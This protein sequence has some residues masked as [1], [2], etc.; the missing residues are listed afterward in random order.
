MTL[1]GVGHRLFVTSERLRVEHA[2]HHSPVTAVLLAGSRE[3]RPPAEDRHQYV[4]RHGEVGCREFE[5][6]AYGLRRGEHD[7]RT[8]SEETQREHVAVAL[9]AG[10][11]QRFRARP[12]SE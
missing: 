10:A 7:D 11:E 3:Q 6:R 4:A 5:H 2:Q 8:A 12:V 9:T 1:G